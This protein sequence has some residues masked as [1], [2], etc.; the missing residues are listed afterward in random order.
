MGLAPGIITILL[1]ASFDIDLICQGHPIPIISAGI[2]CREA[3]R[4]W[5]KKGSSDTELYKGRPG[6]IRLLKAFIW[7]SDGQIHVVAG[8]NPTVYC[9]QYIL[10][11]LES[12]APTEAISICEPGAY[13]GH[14]CLMENQTYQ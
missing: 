13:P 8:R 11:I 10:S 4:E 6:K 9:P 3:T 1:K 5:L 7:F 12:T 2:K 14:Y